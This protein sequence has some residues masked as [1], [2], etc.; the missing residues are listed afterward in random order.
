MPPNCMK[1]LRLALVVFA[2]ALGIARA[3]DDER[4]APPTEIPDF[5]NL[6]EYIYEP[7]STVTLGFR[8]LSGAKTTFSGRGSVPAPE[9]PGPKTGANLFR[10]YHDGSV[11]P[12][13]RI[14]PQFDPAGNPIMDGASQVF[15]PIAPDGKTNTWSYG[16]LRQLS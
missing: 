6:D 9:D 5:S 8:H 10:L 12:D 4:R 13:Q 1:Y 14:A 3:Q 7:K 11:E 2:S 15:A 16:D